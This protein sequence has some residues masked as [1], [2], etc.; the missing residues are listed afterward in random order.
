M[1]LKISKEKIIR[2]D[3]ENKLKNSF[4]NFWIKILTH[5]VLRAQILSKELGTLDGLIIQVIA[6]HHYLA[7]IS[8]VSKEDNTFDT[9]IDLWHN[10]EIKKGSNKKL[11]I[12]LVSQ[13]TAIPFETTR[14]KINKLKEKNWI[15]YSKEKG[16][17]YNSNSQLND[18][19]I[20]V[21]H[22]VEKDLLKEFLVAYLL[23]DD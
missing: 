8:E 23:S 2:K 1:G 15:F 11:T 22:P 21:I 4:A 6:W 9:A 7:T 18:K 3:V 5:N 14:R 10:K 12:T 13:L 16:I 17:I 19:I 20:N